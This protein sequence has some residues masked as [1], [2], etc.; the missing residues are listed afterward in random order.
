MSSESGGPSGAG[1]RGSGCCGL[2]F[3]PRAQVESC[4]QLGSLEAGLALRG[5][6]RQRHAALARLKAVLGNGIGPSLPTK[7]GTPPLY[8][9]LKSEERIKINLKLPRKPA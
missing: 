9:G 1:G 5:P 7:V 4:P 2:A 6:G 8:R 3:F